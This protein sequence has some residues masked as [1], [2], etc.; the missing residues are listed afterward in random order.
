[1]SQ[2]IKSEPVRQLL[3]GKNF[4]YLATLMPDGSPQVTP[5][6]LD[7]D[8]EYIIV[9]TALGR[10]KYENVL[11]DPRVAISV[12]DNA[13]PYSMVAVRGEVVEHTTSGAEEHID[14]MAKKYMGLDKYPGRAPGEK[15]VILKIKPTKIFLQ[16]YG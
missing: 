13:N 4:G 9:N 7:T 8:G 10:L 6:W 2:T 16:K 14:K 12:A 3:Q 11:R 1:M 5:T 15:R